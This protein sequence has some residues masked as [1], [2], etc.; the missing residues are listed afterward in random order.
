MYKEEG[1]RQLKEGEQREPRGTPH[2][3]RRGAKHCSV[4]FTLQQGSGGAALS[5]LGSSGAL[6]GGQGEIKKFSRHLE[7]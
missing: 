1:L 6:V 7:T 4:S 3:K 2:H 5:G